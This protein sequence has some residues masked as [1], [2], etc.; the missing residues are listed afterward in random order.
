MKTAASKTIPFR[1]K[2]EGNKISKYNRINSNSSNNV[3]PYPKYRNKKKNGA[4]FIKRN[5]HILI[6]VILA[7][8]FSFISYSN[9][10][11]KLNDNN[12]N[13]KN[14]SS[15][16]SYS[17]ITLTPTEFN[18]NSKI[19]SKE[20]KKILNLDSDYKISTKTMHKNGT[21]IYAQGSYKTTSKEEVYFDI[22]L[23]DN[24]VSSLVV[25][26]IE[27]INKLNSK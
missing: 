22:L 16:S 8:C 13:S 7:F 10:K 6:L 18:N 24:K 5:K 21:S 26:G 25:N 1:Q 17:K 4:K 19:I 11:I 2:F 14:A 12:I 27:Y 23:K 20:V 9:N 15:N 3:I